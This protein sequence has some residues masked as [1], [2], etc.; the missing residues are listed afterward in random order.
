MPM[1][2]KCKISDLD[3]DEL[4]PLA[5]FARYLSNS[6]WTVR[7]WSREG[8]YD[9]D[10]RQIVRLEVVKTGKGMAT[11]RRMYEKFIKNLNCMGD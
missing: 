4:V 2:V 9:V 8:T 3:H 10:N 6:Y 7:R 5:E 11:S 1:A